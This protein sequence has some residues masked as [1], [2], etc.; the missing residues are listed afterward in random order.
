MTRHR[1]RAGSGRDQ[2]AAELVE[3]NDIYLLGGVFRK[4]AAPPLH[5]IELRIGREKRAMPFALT[6]TSKPPDGL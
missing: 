6:N 1:R 2:K 4:P 5:R 3:L